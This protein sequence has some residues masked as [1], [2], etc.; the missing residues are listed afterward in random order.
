MKIIR[1]KLLLVIMVLIKIIA[2]SLMIINGVGSL[3]AILFAITVY[4]F[5]DTQDSRAGFENNLKF[6]I[7][8]TLL[9]AMCFSSTFSI[10][11]YLNNRNYSVAALLGISPII[12]SYAN[13]LD[14]QPS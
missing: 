13:P 11:A 4:L 3:I 1:S 6:I 7:L 12:Y 9:L 5:S 14:Q 2:I 10:L 8:F